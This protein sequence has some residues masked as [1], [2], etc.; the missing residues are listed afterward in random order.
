[1][2]FKGIHTKILN[3][4]SKAYIT[5]SCPKTNYPSNEVFFQAGRVYQTQYT[6]IRRCYGRGLS[7]AEQ[8]DRIQSMY[9]EAVEVQRSAR[10]SVSYYFKS[11]ILSERENTINT[12]VCLIILERAPLSIVTS[13][14]FR[15]AFRLTTDVSVDTVRETII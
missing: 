7:T 3:R 4:K 2:E 6:H 8:S 13:S 15:R 12:F 14:E 9:T 1:M 11:E 10:G 5:Y